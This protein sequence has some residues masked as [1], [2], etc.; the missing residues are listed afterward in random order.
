MTTLDNKH[1]TIEISPSAIASIVA[2]SVTQTYGVVGMSTPSLA[3]GIAATITRDPHKGVEVNIN[4]DN[5]DIDLYVVLEYGIRIASVATSL[6]NIVRY[7][8]EKHTGMP[9]NSIK[10]HV[11]GIRVS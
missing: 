9:V 7:T 10:I 11:Q 6:I 1:G 8:V 4:E 5:I 3:S 2:N